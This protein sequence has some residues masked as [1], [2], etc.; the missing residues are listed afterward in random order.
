MNNN[1]TPDAPAA[2]PLAPYAS[3]AP[4]T[5]HGVM[6]NILLPIEI[7]GCAPPVFVVISVRSEGHGENEREA[8]KTATPEDPYLRPSNITNKW[9]T[10]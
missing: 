4:Q 3:P 5:D 2:L 7:D 1:I 6:E 9:R 10:L 8:S